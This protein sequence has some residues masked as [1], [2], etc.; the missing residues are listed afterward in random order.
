M[1]KTLYEVLG[2]PKNASQER[3]EAAY[4]ALL[5]KYQDLYD[6]GDPSAQTA[7][8]SLKGAYEILSNPAKRDDYDEQQA[9]LLFQPDVPATPA[10]KRAA[11]VPGEPI[12]EPVVPAHAEAMGPCL[13]CGQQ[14]SLTARTCP[15]CGEDNSIVDT[16]P[17]SMPKIL[18]LA[19]SATL[20]LG[21]FMPVVSMP[22]VGSMN[23]FKNGEGDGVI[24]LVLAAISL[25]LA[26]LG[27]YRR[28]WLTGLGSLGVLAF[29]FI[30]FQMKLGEIKEKMD[31]DLA[32]N[33]FRG[34]A[35]AAMAAIQLQWGWAVLALGAALV[36]AAAITGGKAEESRSAG[37]S[38]Q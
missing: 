11:H 12:L 8:F 29:S 10:R 7:L 34:L 32:G 38:D 13:V 27:H 36:I 9:R 35:D 24:I 6:Q 33:P 26:L 30:H 20:F 4:T 2:V 19:G 28:L 21:V 25:V 15:H 18:G 22:I 14:I 23:Y 17:G 1:N 31:V 16:A 5:V 3:I 37:R